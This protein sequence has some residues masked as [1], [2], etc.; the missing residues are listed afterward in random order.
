ML[1]KAYSLMRAYEKVVGRGRM[2]PLQRV[3][4]DDVP[5]GGPGVEQ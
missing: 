5:T 1:V 4:E 2:D 3:R